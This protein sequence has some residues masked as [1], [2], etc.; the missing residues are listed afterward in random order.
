MALRL[1]KLADDAIEWLREK[2]NTL[3]REL[4]IGRSRMVKDPYK[5]ISEGTK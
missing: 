1:A 4:T 5:I 2:F 3:R